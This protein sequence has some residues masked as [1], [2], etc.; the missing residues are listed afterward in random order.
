[1]Q[2]STD[3]WKPPPQSVFKLNFDAAIFMETGTFGF[4]VTVRNDK[5][6]VMAAVSAKGP[7]VSSIDKIEM[8]AYRK[9]MEYGGSIRLVVH[10]YWNMV[11]FQSQPRS[12]SIKH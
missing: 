6:E 10:T 9:E 2:S 1:M 4:S 5:G 12:S 8:L 3:V 7:P 11:I